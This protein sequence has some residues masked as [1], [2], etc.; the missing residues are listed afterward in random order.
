MNRRATP[1]YN[2][3][4]F[5][6][7]WI[8]TCLPFSSP[9]QVLPLAAN[10]VIKNDA[11]QPGKFS[12]EA[13][14]GQVISLDVKQN[15]MDVNV[16]LFG[17]QKVLLAE[18]DYPFSEQE[19]ER[20][21]VV[22]A[23]DGNYQLEI[24]SKFP[25]RNGHVKVT[26]DKLRPSVP[27]D[28]KQAEAEKLL[29]QAQA[30]RATGDTNDRKAAVGVY[31]RSLRFWRE[32]GHETGQLRALTNL[33]Y[34]H[35]ILQSYRESSELAEQVL[36]F[37]D[38]N[39]SAPYKADALY[40]LGRMKF[41][42]GA[43]PESIEI[44]KRAI[45]QFPAPAPQQA[46]IYASIGDAYQKLAEF[47]FAQAAFD[48]A[49]ENIRQFP[50][51]YNEAQVRHTL[52]LMFLTLK[53]F[54][55]SI[56]NLKIAANFREKYGYRRGI[57]SALAV[58]GM[59]YTYIKK[60]PESMDVLQKALPISRQFRDRETEA[61]ILAYMAVNYREMGNPIKA[62]E[63]LREALS[64]FPDKDS[65]DLSSVYITLGVTLTQLS[66]FDEA[67]DCFERS[68]TGYRKTGDLDGE[69]RTLYHFAKLER[70][71]NKLD[72]AGSKI[73]HALQNH[74]YVQA[75]YYNAQRLSAF[76]EARRGYFD[77]YIDILM[78][79]DAERP[80]D[81]F[82]VKA[83]QVS[84]NARMRTLIWY[85]RESLKNDRQSEDYLLLKKIKKVRQEIGDQLS[86]L[87][88]A[89]SNPNR[90][91]TI[92]GI[93]NSIAGL[94]KEDESLK[95]QFRLIN[96]GFANLSQPPELSLAQMQDELDPDTAVIEYSLGEER[97]YL[98]IVTKNDFQ[99]FV[100]P[101]RTEIDAQARLFYES[102][103]IA[104]EPA[105]KSGSKKKTGVDAP[106][107]AR[108]REESIKLG[109]LISTE[110]FTGLSVKRLVF[111]A[112]GALDLIPFSSLPL[113]GTSPGFIT[114]KFEIMRLPSLTTLHVVRQ[115]GNRPFA[116][117][118]LAVFADPV[119]SPND[120][121]VA[122]SRRA[123]AKKRG[124]IVDT[125]LAVALRDFNLNTFPRLPFSRF[126]AGKIADNS[127]FTTA[128]SLDFRAS[129]DR[130]FDGE[131][132]RYDIVHFATHGV[133]NTQHP[134][135]SGL[136]LSLVDENGNPRENGFLRTQDLFSIKL[137]PQLVVLSACQ[138]GLGKQV[139]N[140]GLIGLTRGFLANGTPRVVSTLWK[141][142]DSA[143]AEFMGR[144]YRALLKENQSPSAALRTTQNELKAIRRF[145]HPRYWAGFVLTGEWR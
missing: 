83:L 56:D 86:K 104:G 133:L 50:D 40:Q 74:E 109:R 32:I 20:I 71:Q 122:G 5:F 27:D 82:A 16:K 103:A 81:N 107:I 7:V 88:Q 144:F 53:D 90:A 97:S 60:I 77:L 30:L 29:S 63:L 22:A 91:K 17:P 68:L 128:L 39:E 132:D 85:Y 49:L 61:N 134:E 31:Q 52:G 101:K 15:G 51:M 35:R 79:L 8:L 110:K 13:K 64:L 48:Q 73:E 3:L 108:A 44:L 19:F 123:G 43:I 4:I 54:D 130:L 93:E 117:R 21:F 94:N 47:E 38:S 89:Q 141:V 92:P 65:V 84:E 1:S 67:R 139:E 138:T 69:T 18:S 12:I 42:G 121:R 57:A 137:K 11:R 127:P 6:A 126:E 41:I 114:D 131:F 145:S 112:D 26:L 24:H 135:L 55:S 113:S 136:V 125:H 37:H 25:D 120:E 105:G 96:P 118:S 10:L 62:V 33:A 78:R 66:N 111:V 142:D 143:T 70:A 2:R 102:V 75:K 119:F 72:A 76:Q 14:K 45:S 140:E 115:T 98:W 100:L 46:N 95:A 99:R 106:D 116:P 28:L 124:P 87:A 59:D 9:G 34:L 36:A 129:R 80:S 23:E 58:L